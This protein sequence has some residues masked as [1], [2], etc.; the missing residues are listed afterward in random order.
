MIAVE[1][2][3]CFNCN[4]R[5]QT[6]QNFAKLQDFPPFVSSQNDRTGQDLKRGV[7]I[8]YHYSVAVFIYYRLLS[9]DLGVTS[10]V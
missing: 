10:N 9:C 5:G 3:N 4:K 8:L 2:K 6:D 7:V 1:L